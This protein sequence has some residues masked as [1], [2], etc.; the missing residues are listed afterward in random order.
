MPYHVLGTGMEH[1]IR[2]VAKGT[3]DHR[4]GEG[5]VHEIGKSRNNF[6]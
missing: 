3:G 1:E 6:V 2:A 5:I 4:R